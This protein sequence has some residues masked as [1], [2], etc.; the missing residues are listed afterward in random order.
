MKSDLFISIVLT[1]TY[2]ILFSN[3]VGE[4][5]NFPNIIFYGIT[6]GIL[7]L[8]ISLVLKNISWLSRKV[9]KLRLVFIF[10]IVIILSLSSLEV[11]FN[12]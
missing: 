1:F 5:F 7:F 10:S 6:S 4:M 2:I 12:L 11:Y 3:K 9:I 8:L